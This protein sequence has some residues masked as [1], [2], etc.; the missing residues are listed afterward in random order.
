[1]PTDSC[2]SVGVFPPAQLWWETMSPRAEGH[3]MGVAGGSEN[4]PSGI[5]TLANVTRCVIC[6]IKQAA[7]LCLGGWVLSDDGV[8]E[9]QGQEGLGLL[10]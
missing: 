7:Y 10:D 8:R 1:M 4:S 9:A 5:K 6:F 3:R 2:V